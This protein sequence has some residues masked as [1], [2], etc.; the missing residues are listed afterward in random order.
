VAA[1]VL[2]AVR[3]AAA[4][5][6]AFD[7]V[8]FGQSVYLSRFYEDSQN[9][10]GVQFVNITEFRRGDVTTPAV[11]PHGTIVLG[12]NEVPIVPTVSAYALGLNVV[13]VDQGG[14]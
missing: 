1:D 11:E 12:P 8:D 9:V 4:A 3:Q 13:L 5:L 10:P 6:L 2:A 7:N 14:R